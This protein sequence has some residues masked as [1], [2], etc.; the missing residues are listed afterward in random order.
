ML[1]KKAHNSK[2]LYFII[3]YLLLF[4]DDSFITGVPSQ[5][6]RKPELL[7]FIL[8]YLKLFY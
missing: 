2:T 1:N 8:V 3:I 5:N 4:Y 6:H 7:F